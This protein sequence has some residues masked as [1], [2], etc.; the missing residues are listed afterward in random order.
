[1]RGWPAALGRARAQVQNAA[2]PIRAIVMLLLALLA[3]PALTAGDDAAAI[4]ARFDQ[5]IQ[6]RAAAI[7]VAWGAEPLCDNVTE[8]EPFV[9]WSVHAARGKLSERDAGLLKQATGMD[10]KWRVA[11]MDEAAPDDLKI[12]DVVVAINGRELPGAKRKFDLGA[13]FK[14]GSVLSTDDNGFWEVMLK[15]R[16]EADEETTP[17][18]LTLEDGRKLKVD[19]QS[20]CAGSVTASAFDEN[21]A[22]FWNQGSARV[23]LPSAAMLEARGRDEFRWLAAFGT[24]FQASRKAIGNARDAEDASTKFTVGKILLLA[25]PGAGTLLTAAEANYERALVVTSS[26]GHADLFANEVVA[27]LGGDPDAGLR[28]SERLAAKGT[29]ADAVVM[30]AWRRSNATEHAKRLREMKAEAPAATR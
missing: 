8:I 25:V 20:G 17:M 5:E 7:H 14:G 12:G 10:D 1:M 6:F 30:D 24:Y 18:T 27:A 15:A 22:Q 16:E 13:V 21:P 4:Q 9:L 28:L 2:M 3:V 26:V 29:K 19:T 23:K 11:W